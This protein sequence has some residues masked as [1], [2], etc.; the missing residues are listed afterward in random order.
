MRCGNLAGRIAHFIS[1]AERHTTSCPPWSPPPLHLRPH[2]PLQHALKHQGRVCHRPQH[3]TRVNIEGYATMPPTLVSDAA[4]CGAG[5]S[6]SQNPGHTK[7]Q[8]GVSNARGGGLQP[9]RI[10]AR[11]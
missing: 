7:K 9:P 6:L 8:Y 1:N 11:S 5:R 2:L 3:D 10:S 4:G